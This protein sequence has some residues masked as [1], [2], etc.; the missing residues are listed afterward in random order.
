MQEHWMDKIESWVAY[1]KK[2][3]KSRTMWLGA[4]VSMLGAVQGIYYQL[5]MPW[6]M[7]A[8]SYVVIGAVMN[9]LR[10]DTHDSI[11]DK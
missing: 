5:P 7:Q 6:Y 4:L 2:C 10:A 11:T 1:L 8:M 9:L 3:A